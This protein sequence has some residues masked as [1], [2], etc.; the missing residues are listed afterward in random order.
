MNRET[1]LMHQIMLATTH[2]VD[3]MRNNVGVSERN[4]HVIR[5]GLGG[6]GGAD[7]IGLVIGTGRFIA[8]EVK[9]P[10]KKPTAEQTQF[11]A[12]VT[13]NGGIAVLAHSVGDVLKALEGNNA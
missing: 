10:G 5:Y 8:C 1:H 12:R 13:R 11:L 7:L 9:M 3:W 4:G 2:L 6:N